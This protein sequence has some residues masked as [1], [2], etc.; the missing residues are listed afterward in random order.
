[1]S[2]QVRPGTCRL[3]T[4]HSSRRRGRLGTHLVGTQCTTAHRSSAKIYPVHSKSHCYIDSHSD[5]LSSY[6]LL[7]YLLGML[8]MRC[9]RCLAESDH[10]STLCTPSS[11][12][13]PRTC[14]QCMLCSWTDE[15]RPETCPHDISCNCV[16]HPHPETGPRRISCTQTG[17]SDLDAR[18]WSNQSSSTALLSSEIARQGIP[19]RLGHWPCRR[20]CQRRITCNRL[21]NLSCSEIDR[22]STRCTRSCGAKSGSA[23]LHKVCSQTVPAGSENFQQ[24]IPCNWIALFDFESATLRCV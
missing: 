10:V 13:R 5:Q 6:S 18:L 4:S 8:C 12:A 23:P 19:Y 14:P 9:R 11:P 15:R 22:L 1:M 20:T 21:P 17:P 24:D 3:D 7:F 16:A 2:D